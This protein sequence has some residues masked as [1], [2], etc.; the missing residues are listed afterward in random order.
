M[1]VWL[2]MAIHLPNYIGSVAILAYQWEIYIYRV[3]V[4]ILLA[5]CIYDISLTVLGVYE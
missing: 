1:H 5:H 4:H 3:Y 2:G